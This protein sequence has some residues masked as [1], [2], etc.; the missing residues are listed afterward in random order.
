MPKCPKCGSSNIHA[1]KRGFS[2]K[3]SL[4]GG[5]LFGAVGLLG[6]AVGSNKIRLTCLDCGNQFK[7]GDKAIDDIS[8]VMENYTLIGETNDVT[9][10]KATPKPKGEHRV[11]IE[12]LLK[13]RNH[14]ANSKVGLLE[15]MLNEGQ[16]FVIVP[17][18]EIEQLCKLQRENST[19]KRIVTFREC[20]NVIA[21]GIWSDDINDTDKREALKLIKSIKVGEAVFKHNVFGVPASFFVDNFEKFEFDSRYKLIFRAT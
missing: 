3:K 15:A 21:N 5:I 14:I 20:E 18:G 17:N 6:G 8:S 1:D 19:I 13:Y 2:T 11:R 12:T 7:P 9:P 16:E 10:H 4:V